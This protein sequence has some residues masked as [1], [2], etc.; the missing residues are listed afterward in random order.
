MFQ[1]D[2]ENETVL[3][4]GDYCSLLSS[5]D[6]FDIDLPLMAKRA[7]GGTMIMWRKALDAFITPLYAPS[8]SLLPILFTPPGSPPSIHI[9]IYL[10]TAGRDI[11]FA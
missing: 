4:K 3:F 8:S 1:C 7:K 9:A 10:P 5:D 6:A 11:D 2:L